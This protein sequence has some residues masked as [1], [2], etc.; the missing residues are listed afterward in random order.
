MLAIQLACVLLLVAVA[1][2]VPEAPTRLFLWATLLPLA[3]GAAFARA[4]ARGERVRKEGAWSVAWE[5]KEARRTYQ[6]LGAV[7]LGWALGMVAWVVATR[8]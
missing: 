5:R 6:A 1:F 3:F 2:L 7:V 8:A 4:Y